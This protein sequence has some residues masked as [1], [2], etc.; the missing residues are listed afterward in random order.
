MPS[1]AYGPASTP[2]PGGESGNGA[3]R[4][5]PP[6]ACANQRASPLEGYAK[7]PT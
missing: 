6:G 2:K 7:G 3:E 5:G 1:A 4:S